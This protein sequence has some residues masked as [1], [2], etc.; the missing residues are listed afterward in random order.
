MPA[1]QLQENLAEEL[2]INEFYKIQYAKYKKNPKLADQIFKMEEKA[3][4]RLMFKTAALTLAANTILNHDEVYLK[5][6]NEIVTPRN[7]IVVDT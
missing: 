4:L 3:D 7:I 2:N 1:F 6:K 5:D